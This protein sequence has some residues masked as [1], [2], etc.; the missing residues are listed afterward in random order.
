MSRES[1]T[2][3]QINSVLCQKRELSFLAYFSMDYFLPS[4]LRREAG[5]QAVPIVK[6]SVFEKLLV[7]W[8]IASE[9]AME[10]QNKLLGVAAQLEAEEAVACKLRQQ[11]HG[12]MHDLLTGRVR[13]KLASGSK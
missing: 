6:K 11:K 5:L 4:Q 12:L 13:V 10:V 7:A 9:E 8:P 3:Q 2:N 1:I